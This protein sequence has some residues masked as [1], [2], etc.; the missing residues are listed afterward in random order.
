[1]RLDMVW[2]AHQEDWRSG[3]TAARAYTSE[4][5]DLLVPYLYV[6]EDGFP[7]GRSITK[8]RSERRKGALMTERVAELDALGMVWDRR[9][10]GWLRW[11][12][13]ARA[14]RE[15]NGDLRAS[16]GALASWLERLRSQRRR[17]VLPSE[18]IAE[19]DALGMAWD[20]YDEDWQRGISAARAY[21]ESHRDL[22][23][24]A[25]R[26][27]PTDSG[28]AAGSQRD[29]LSAAVVSFQTS[30]SLNL[31]RSA[32][33]GIRT[34]MTGSAG[35]P[36]R[37]HTA[38]RTG[39]SGFRAVTSRAT[40]SGLKDGSSS[41]DPSAGGGCSPMSASLNST[42]SVWAG[43]RLRRTGN[44]G[45]KPR[46]RSQRITDT[47]ACQPP[48][49]RRTDSSSAYGFRTVGRI[50]GGGVSPTGGSLSWM[51]SGWSGR[52]QWRERDLQHRRQPPRVQLDPSGN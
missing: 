31:T 2:S 44:D 49:R 5:G 13:K 27:P 33:S 47:F 21:R 1:M 32:W 7:L 19:L 34:Q 3:I 52:A 15:A 26:L 40:D 14:Y 46:G 18:R 37:V 8:R 6:T 36:L 51:R 28:S 4:N 25:K 50:V 17:G 35:S 24:S 10:E 45:L 29:A 43:S 42:R 41:V 23:V 30:E 12:A 9:E 16:E 11:L 48:T 20:P 22:L 38:R 39:I